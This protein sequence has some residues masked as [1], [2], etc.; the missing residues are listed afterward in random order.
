M[1]LYIYTHTHVDI[2]SKSV[3]FLL[4]D[5]RP[6]LMLHTCV[7]VC[8]CPFMHTYMYTPD[9]VHTHTHTH[10]HTHNAYAC[11]VHTHNTPGSDS[12]H[13]SVIYLLLQYSIGVLLMPRSD[14]ENTQCLHTSYILQKQYTRTPD[15]FSST[16]DAQ[17]LIKQL[18]RKGAGNY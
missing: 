2:L 18:G 4:L 9:N 13:L 15:T 6:L 3:I 7:C 12:Q 10:T 16:T 17:P 5:P 14:H 1:H 8:A 11:Q